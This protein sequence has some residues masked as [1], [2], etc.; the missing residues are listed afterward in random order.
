MKQAGFTLLELIVGLVV[1]GFILAG[2]S[3]GVR[4]GLRASE[5]QSRLVDSRSELDAVDRALRRLLVDA[6]PGTSHDPPTLQGGPAR[7]VFVSTLPAAV[8]GRPGEQADIALAV[9]G[10]HRLVLRWS[11]HLHAQRT[12]PPPPPGEA[13]LLRGVDHI[14]LA[15][16]MNGWQSGWTAAN[17]PALIRLRITFSP[18]D[19]RRWPDLVVA[20]LRGRFS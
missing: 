5:T 8:A 15:Y 9:D 14:E 18:D 12:A 3:Q 13:E 6:D 17:L 4:F 1:L 20:P 10:G 7:I 2:L 19:P 16:W 11:P